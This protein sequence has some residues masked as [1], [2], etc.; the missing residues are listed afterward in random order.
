[1]CLSDRRCQTAVVRLPLSD[2]PGRALV[3]PPPGRFAA[4]RIFAT[5]EIVVYYL[6]NGVDA[7]RGADMMSF[8]SWLFRLDR[9]PPTT[10]V[11]MLIMD[12]AADGVGGAWTQVPRAYVQFEGKLPITNT[13][14]VMIEVVHLDLRRTGVVGDASNVRAI[15]TPTEIPVG[16][17]LVLEFKVC[18]SPV[19][20]S[21][22]PWLLADVIMWDA[23]ARRHKL[24]EVKFRGNNVSVP[25]TAAQR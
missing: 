5:G 1:M 4:C 7:I 2:P 21:V 9:T 12:P 20:E 3:I 15:F 10:P 14:H 17:S 11:D 6:P 23:D 24:S 16:R 13:S 19:F 22:G 25:Q 18:A 8:F